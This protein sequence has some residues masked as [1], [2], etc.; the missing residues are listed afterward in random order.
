MRTIGLDLGTKTC[1]FAISDSLGISA[2]ALYTIR[3]DLNDFSMVEDEL[4]KII[5][6]YKDVDSIVIGLPLRSDGSYSERTQL[7][8]EF[9]KKISLKNTNL[10][11]YLVNEYGSTKQAESTL[12]QTKMSIA[13]RKKVKDTVSS[14]IILQ[15]FLNYGGVKL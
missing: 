11:V 6:E 13:K 15:D 10:N 2:N 9:A 8:Y 14:V 3:F 12:K 5:S 1:G 7:F 4:I